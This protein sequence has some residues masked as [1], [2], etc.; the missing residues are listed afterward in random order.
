MDALDVEDGFDVHQYRT[1][2]KLLRQDDG[3]MTLENRQGL[4]CPTCARPFERLF[5]TDDAEVC[6]SSAPNGP[7]CLVR[8]DE[9]LLVLT[10]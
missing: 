7:I 10:H 4:A 6:F 5:V 9:Q 8:T 3:S 1:A 2:L